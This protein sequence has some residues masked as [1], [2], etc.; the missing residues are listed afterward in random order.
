MA[1]VNKVIIVG[2]LGRDPMIRY[3]PS[4]DVIAAICADYRVSRASAAFKKKAGFAGPESKQKAKEMAS[5][6]TSA[7][8]AAPGADDASGSGDDDGGDGDGD[9]DGPR[10]L[11]QSNFPSATRLPPRAYRRPNLPKPLT[12]RAFA[13]LLALA[14]LLAYIGPPGF[15]LIFVRLGHPELAGEMLRYKPVLLVPT[16]PGWTTSDDSARAADTAFTAI[17]STRSARAE[18]V[19][20]GSNAAPSTQAVCTRTAATRVSTQAPHES[21]SAAQKQLG[22]RHAVTSRAH[23]ARSAPKAH[24]H[25]S[26]NGAPS[27]TA[28]TSI[29]EAVAQD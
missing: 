8:T 24:T 26:C 15:A 3:M 2:N 11:S 25:Y 21:T 18:V 4:G 23:A 13:W 14:L 28:G 20:T 29:A 17:A 5:T 1:T 22:R 12:R 19:S 6:A 9:G 10:R 7:G 16:P 27:L